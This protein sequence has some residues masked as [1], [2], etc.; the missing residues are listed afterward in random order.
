MLVALVGATT[1]VAANWGQVTGLASTVAGD[2]GDP[3]YFAW[4]LAWVGRALRSDPTGLWTT[5]AFLRAPDNLAFTDTVLGYAPLSMA[6]PGG[7]TGALAGLN[8]AELTA[9]VIAI[10]GGYDPISQARLRT[11]VQDFPSSASVAELKARGISTV[12]VIRAMLGPAERADLSR[13]PAPGLTLTAATSDLV[14][15]DVR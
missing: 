7:V 13:P 12:V 6:L 8:L 5:N 9:G 3:L 1:T 15:Y 10:L 4:Q 14:V 2:L 11:R